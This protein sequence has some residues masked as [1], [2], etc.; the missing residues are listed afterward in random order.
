MKRK[1]HFLKI[2]PEYFEMVRSG[3]KPFEVRK[4]DRN[5]KVGDTLILREFDGENYTGKEFEVDILCVF[6]EPEYVKEG[7]V[8]LGLNYF[9]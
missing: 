7:F 2:L 5:F 6:D 4:N 1:Q 8:I 9:F 3:N